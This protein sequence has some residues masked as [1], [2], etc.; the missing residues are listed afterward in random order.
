MEKARALRENESTKNAKI[1][2]AVAGIQKGKAAGGDSDLE[3][4]SEEEEDGS[5]DDYDEEEGS[6][7]ESEIEQ[8]PVKRAKK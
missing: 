8:P 4:G 5:D 2:A 6:D 3:S 1:N 7:E